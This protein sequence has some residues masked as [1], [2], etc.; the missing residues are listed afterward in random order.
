MSGISRLHVEPARIAV[1]LATVG[2]VI[3]L[4][5]ATV[6]PVAAVAPKRS[7]GHQSTAKITRIGTGHVGRK[8]AGAEPNTIDQT[9]P[10]P[11]EAREEAVNK[12]IPNS[13]SAARV[14]SSHV[15]RPAALPV[16]SASSSTG[17]DGLNHFDQRTAGTGDYVNTQ[18]SLEPP[19]QAM[20]VGG[21]F[22]VESVNTA[23]RVRSTSGANLTPAVAL[24]Q[25]FGL[26]PE[27]V[28]PDGPF[29]EFT[30][31]P[32][33]YFDPD[34][35]RFYL[36]LLEID[37]DPETGDFGDHSSVLIAVSKTADPTGD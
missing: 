23:L 24:N 22:V 10:D 35:A 12:A 2:A 25:F 33:C 20:C 19:D 32:K 30:S 4:I 21:G 37:I 28:R 15:P 11:E 9:Q 6:T 18:F 14:P 8:A 13:M 3:G 5:A 7:L 16:A 36:T 1:R 31:D 26:S 34:T 27:V 17:F 29:G